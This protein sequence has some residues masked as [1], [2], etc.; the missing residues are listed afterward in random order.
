MVVVSPDILTLQNDSSIWCPDITRWPSYLQISWHTSPDIF[1]LHNDCHIFRYPYIKQRFS[2]F[3][4][5]W[6]CMLMLPS[7]SLLT[8][9]WFSYPQT[10]WP[11]TV[12]VP[13]PDTWS[14]TV[15]VPSPD[16]LTLHSGR[17]ISRHLTL[18][19]GRSISRQPDL[20]QWP[21]HLQTSW[22]YTVAI[23]SPDILTLHSGRS[24]S[25]HPD[26]TQYISW[27]YTVTVPISI[28]IS[29]KFVPKGQID[30]K[31]ALVQVM[32]WRWRVDKPFPEL[33][34]AQFTDT[35]IRHWGKMS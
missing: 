29:L 27:H 4:I 16:I 33:M 10:S 23:P 14:Y 35:Y 17:S 7:P 30:N 24:I 12:A 22:P 2:Y 26:L 9:Q 15:A 11:Y 28:S 18:H 8:I 1:T 34:L 20:T 13:S 21:F 5:S 31:S 3:Q 19:S 25:R 32:A 6:H